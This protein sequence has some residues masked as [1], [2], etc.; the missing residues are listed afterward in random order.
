MDKQNDLIDLTRIEMPTILDREIDGVEKD[1]FGHRHFASALKSIIENPKHNP[2]FSIGLLGKW[3]TGKSSIKNLYTRELSNSIQRK[4]QIQYINFNAWRF[5]GENL[6]RA[7]LKYLYE[8][9][10]GD[11]TY[12]KDQ[13]F[14]KTSTPQLKPKTWQQ[15]LNEIYES[16]VWWLVP[17]TI[18]LAIFSLVI[19]IGGI[20]ATLAFPVEEVYKYGA[21]FFALLGVT[22]FTYFVGKGFSF[23]KFVFQ[24]YDRVTHLKEPITAIEEFEMLLLEQIID[25]KKKNHK[26]SRIVVF[27]DDLDRL[28]ADE[29]ISGI[30]AVRSFMEI[31][32]E[33][34]PSGLGMVFVIS[35]DEEKITEAL[36]R[37]A[38]TGMIVSKD[39]AKRYLDRLFQFRLEI[40]PFPKLDMRNY[41]IEKF[42]SHDLQIIANSIEDKGVKIENIVD[43]M[44]HV[45]VQ[46]PRNALQILNAFLQSWWIANKREHEGDGSSRPGGLTKGAVT[47]HPLVLAVLSTFKVDYPQFY[48]DLIDEPSLIDLFTDF[49]INETIQHEELSYKSK[50]ILS[51][52]LNETDADGKKEYS[53]KD[54]FSS[55]RQYIASLR[56]IKWP[57][58]LQA[59]I[60]LSQDPIARKL[61]DKQIAI[62]H[63]VVSGD[64]QGVLD[65][66]GRQYDNKQL[67]N[68]NM[69][70]LQVILDD[71]IHETDTR[72]DLAAQAVASLANRFPSG[73][74]SYFI[75]PLANRIATSNAL[76]SM[77]GLDSIGDVIKRADNAE[78]KEVAKAFIADFFQSEEP[79]NFKIGS[80]QDTP[81]AEQGKSL[82]LQAT[83][84][85]L[86]IR[87]RVSTLGEQEDSALRDWLLQR[88]Y[89][90]DGKVKTTL[91]FELLEGWFNSFENNLLPLI[92]E[93]YTKLILTELTTHPKIAEVI[94]MER[95]I[96]RLEIIYNS[97]INNSGQETL[98][99]FGTHLQQIVQIQPSQLVK[100]SWNYFEKNIKLI[101]NNAIS[102]IT[103]AVFQ[104]LTLALQEQGAWKLEPWDE[105]FS[106][107]CRVVSLKIA[108]LDDNV[109][110][111]I[112]QA[113]NALHDIAL[114]QKE[115]Q[116]FNQALYLLNIIHPFASEEQIQIVLNI[117]I[118]RWPDSLNEVFCEWIADNF[119]GLNEK[120]KEVLF[121][122]LSNKLKQPLT[123]IGSDTAERFVKKIGVEGQKFL[124][125][126]GLLNTSFRYVIEEYKKNNGNQAI[127]NKNFGVFAPMI[128]LSDSPEVYED[129]RY[130]FMQ[131]VAVPAVYETLHQ[132]IMEDWWP[133][134]EH[135]T[136]VYRPQD[137]FN[138]YYEASKISGNVNRSL[139]SLVNLKLADEGDPTRVIESASIL[140]K[141]DQ[142]SAVYT[143]LLFEQPL[144][145]K[146]LES[147][148][149]SANHESTLKHL[150]EII[151]HQAKVSDA[152]TAYS[153]I[154]IILNSNSVDLKIG[155]D[156]ILGCFV[157]SY[158]ERR[159][160]LSH[161]MAD[162]SV[163]DESRKRIWAEIVD[164][165]TEFQNEELLELISEVTKLED[166]MSRATIEE[167]F[168]DLPDLIKFELLPS[169]QNLILKEM[170][171]IFSETDQILVK[172]LVL[173]WLKN[174]DVRWQNVKKHFQS[175]EHSEN[176]QNIVRQHYPKVNL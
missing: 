82:I 64:H 105:F 143:F 81:T 5:G 90:V 39:E 14:T 75:K 171:R 11:P 16:A 130:I 49:F 138:Q 70:I 23:D 47:N 141:K 152:S 63:A 26:I 2:P 126:S 149:N 13:L 107:A 35:C 162:E 99:S 15:I 71:I 144:Q 59:F 135:A 95:T 118:Q 160:L 96:H 6:K 101:E 93:Q 83:E 18:S 121:K 85:V 29:M 176:D 133:E 12:I 109:K 8:E 157:G 161:M 154:K 128:Y 155:D 10:G 88:N 7:L 48:N 62:F 78:Q 40:P 170:V 36:T 100:F 158:K 164:K 3:G 98:E 9:L 28:P 148:L 67:T 153:S 174:N 54:K 21:I 42:K 132:K 103:A 32:E 33:K 159:K 73:D 106:I 115:P 76:R 44:I 20:L 60:E 97:I 74:V 37:R 167:I 120:L 122:Q 52:Y 150:F 65:G 38:Q 134:D 119:V 58:S 116:Y 123:E 127:I 175:F 114:T 102:L 147:I 56:G 137:V 24:R 84:L 68:D 34:L 92:G 91:P 113:I 125:N 53:L 169:N 151:S 166:D 168:K 80:R 139:A 43:R 50:L 142:E 165:H 86:A 145:E 61:G 55:L 94:Q 19:L 146:S 57:V 77:I 17:F 129:F 87:E 72:Q 30:E 163:S 136:K 108:S 173:E 89:S 66:F 156:D 124:I 51:K 110:T 25:F 27:V 41:I 131:N 140:W 69:R 112:L 46:S 104:R 4:K 111:T 45:S 79:M 117:W 1:A 172:N 31:S 22:A